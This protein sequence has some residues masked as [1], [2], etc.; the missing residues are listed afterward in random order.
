MS[1]TPP[2]APVAEIERRL[3]WRVLSIIGFL[4]L[5]VG[6]AVVAAVGVLVPAKMA[7]GLPDDIVVRAAQASL[8]GRV[9]MRAGNLR[10]RSALTGEAP[11]G[12]RF[13]VQEDTLVLRATQLLEGTRSRQR[14]DPRLAVALAHLDLARQRYVRAE[15]AYRAVTD[16]G[17]D[18]PEARLGLGLALALEARAERDP[19]RARAL[20]LEAIA[21]WTA[22]DPRHECWLPA[23]YDRALLLAEVGRRDEAARAAREYLTREPAGPWAL[24][25][26]EA[27]GMTADYGPASSSVQ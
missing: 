10:F 12:A 3:H 6:L 8:S 23:L 14:G 4:V 15:R 21:Q 2:A 19:L 9:P 17:I 7:T 13:G 11:T 1:Q 16:R 26:R 20:R 27:L 5:I 22:V 18:A 24:T 25:L